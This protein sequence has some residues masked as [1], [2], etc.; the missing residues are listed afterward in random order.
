MRSS[1][2]WIGSLCATLLVA[3]PTVPR[4]GGGGGASDDSY[5]PNDSAAAA[6]LIYCGDTITGVGADP[7]WFEVTTT[8]EVPSLR[9]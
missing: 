6:A 3:C 9:F 2:P 8:E 5:E 7:D 1:T 4:G